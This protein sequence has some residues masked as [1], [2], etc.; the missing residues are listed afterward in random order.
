MTND[1]LQG[2]GFNQTLRRYREPSAYFINSGKI[3]ET[4]NTAVPMSDHD[5]AILDRAENAARAR[6][7]AEDRLLRD[8][9]ESKFELP[10]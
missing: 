1:E 7:A 2:N 5:A 9:D 3:D 4:A 8:E 6:A 10:R